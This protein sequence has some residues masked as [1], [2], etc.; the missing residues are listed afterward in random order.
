LPPSCAI[1]GAWP[2]GA[3]LVL[4]LSDGG[5]KSC[6]NILKS[7]ASIWTNKCQWSLSAMC[8]SR[9]LQLRGRRR[10]DVRRDAVCANDP[11]A[12]AT[13]TA[14]AIID[15]DTWTERL[16]SPAASPVANRP[17]STPPTIGEGKEQMITAF[18]WRA[19]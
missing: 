11:R 12:T 13:A 1:V 16:S 14:A 15:I 8:R 10:R 5:D 19:R 6:A 3:G 17:V 9:C 2:V 7:L 18:T 4:E